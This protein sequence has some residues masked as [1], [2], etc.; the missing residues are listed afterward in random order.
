MR[1]RIEV[2]VSSEGR[3]WS[4]PEADEYHTREAADEAL[5]QLQVAFVDMGAYV[6]GRIVDTDTGAVV[7]EH[8]A[9]VRIAS[10]N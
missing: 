4:P 7:H 6:E 10:S 1:Y 9:P 8:H 5:A 2:L 3:W